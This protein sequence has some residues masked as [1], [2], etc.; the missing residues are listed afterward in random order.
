LFAALACSGCRNTVETA[1]KDQLIDPESAIFSDIETKAGVTCGVVNSKNRFGG[2]VGQ[3]VFIYKDGSVFFQD[4][5]D[6]NKIGYGAC[7]LNA[8]SV[9]IRATKEGISTL[10]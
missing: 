5:E 8:L 10:R 9:G 3:R 4:T 1:V 7:S 6:F 2:Y